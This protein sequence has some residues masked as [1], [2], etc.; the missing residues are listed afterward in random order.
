MTGV[1]RQCFFNDPSGNLL[2][3]NQPIAQ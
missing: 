2:E 3:L 1:C